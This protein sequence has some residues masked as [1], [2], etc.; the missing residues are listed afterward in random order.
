MIRPVNQNK[1]AMPLE[2][3]TESAKSGAAKTQTATQAT[4]ATLLAMVMSIKC[5]N[6]SQCSSGNKCIATG[7]GYGECRSRCNNDS[8]CGRAEKCI[9]TGNG[10][11]ECRSRCNK[12]S[13]CEKGRSCRATG[14][15]YG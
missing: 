9:A 15:G 12:D 8:S 6:D 7:N 11:G 14:N 1:S 13:E 3:D 2:M 10:Y 5:N 4:P